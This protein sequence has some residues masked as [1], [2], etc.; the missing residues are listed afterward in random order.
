MDYSHLQ[1]EITNI[2]ERIFN[3][4]RQSEEP[5]RKQ[6]LIQKFAKETDKRLVTEKQVYPSHFY[7]NLVSNRD[8]NKKES[9]LL[10]NTQKISNLIQANN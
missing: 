4:K 5:V 7:T 9:A 6:N 3:R 2:R 10:E 8:F 1:N